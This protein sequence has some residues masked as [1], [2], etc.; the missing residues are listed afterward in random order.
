[1]LSI[2]RLGAGQKMIKTHPDF[3]DCL[4]VKSGW[5]DKIDSELKMYVCFLH[6]YIVVSFH[7]KIFQVIE[8]KQ[9]MKIHAFVRSTSFFSIVTSVLSFFFV[10]RGCVFQTTAVATASG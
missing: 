4:R 6:I 10:Q 7:N 9:K 5:R 2:G 3:Y 1:M 8:K